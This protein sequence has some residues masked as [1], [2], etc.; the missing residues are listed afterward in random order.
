MTPE[1][2]EAKDNQPNSNV[3]RLQYRCVFLGERA[4]GQ[5]VVRHRGCS[6]KQRNVLKRRY[7]SVHLAI[8]TINIISAAL[9][10]GK[11]VAKEYIRDDFTSIYERFTE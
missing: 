4:K 3:K 7:R 2:D 11:I 1:K 5:C 6:L 9:F 8:L 10:G